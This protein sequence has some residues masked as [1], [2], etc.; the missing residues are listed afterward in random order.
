M[1]IIDLTHTI[2]ENMSVYPGT[3]PT[4]LQVVSTHKK[5]GFK[6]TQLIM[7]SHTGTHMD[8]PNHIF[9]EGTTLDSFS[10]EQF[11]GKGLVIDCTD[12]LES[13][14]ITIN[15]I[16]SVKEKANKA[17]FLLF[18]TGF[19]ARWGK[20]SYFREYPC[21][22]EEVI[23]YLIQSKK[24][25]VG[26]DVISID[27]ISDIN[28]TLHKKLLFDNDIVI[29]ENLTNLGDIGSDLFTFLALP[30]KF[31]NSDGAPVRAIAILNN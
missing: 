28:L 13:Q 17:D 10:V 15:Y 16:E 19:N 23:E 26:L 27:P 12:L 1:K 7:F 31:E 9:P 11:I 22:T 29:I 5:D 4:K 8:S 20:N 24:K 3:E 25:G 30:L 21:L 2:S 14:K 18:Y 6:E